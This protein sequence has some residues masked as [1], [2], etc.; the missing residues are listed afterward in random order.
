M[1][2][3]TTRLR[4]VDEYLIFRIDTVQHFLVYIYIRCDVWYTLCLTMDVYYV[5]LI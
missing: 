5:W 1:C 3:D 4:D 2:T